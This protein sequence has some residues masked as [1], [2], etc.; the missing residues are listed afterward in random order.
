MAEETSAALT[1]RELLIAIHLASGESTGQVAQR[2]S[3][4]P[5]TVTAHLRNM[6]GKLGARNRTELTAR[7]YSAG[8]LRSGDWPPRAASAATVAEVTAQSDF[9]AL[10][11]LRRA[12]HPVDM[13]SPEHRAVFASLGEDEI[14]VL[15]SI[16]TLLE[17]TVQL[18]EVEGQ[19]VKIL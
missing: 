8:V 11:E 2:L 18:T 14:R 13:L 3:I 6:L 17:T 7:L 19:E 5:H 12:G 1:S 16:K 15:N 4:S 10:D 9:D